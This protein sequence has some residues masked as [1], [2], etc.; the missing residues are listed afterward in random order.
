MTSKISRKI[1]AYHGKIVSVTN[2]RYRSWEHCY[3]FFQK[4]QMDAI[5]KDREHAALHLAFYL[6]SWGMYRGSCWLLQYD[7]TVHLHVVDCL[8]APA[9]RPLWNHEFGSGEG[10]AER[11][12]VIL[13]AVERVR[14]AYQKTDEPTNLLITKVLL[15]TLGCIPAFD[16]FFTDGFKSEGLPCWALNEA[17][18]NRILDFTHNNLDTLQAEQA[19]IKTK[20][21]CFYP[22]MKLVD[23][24]FWQVGYERALAK[25]G[26]KPPVED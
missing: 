18:L 19:R 20:T 17:L 11:V 3:Q 2:Y 15:G 24:Y 14:R 16:Q 25:R 10:D 12:P 6:A 8:V 21:R 1:Q 23:M 4:A 7:F 5:A 13:D 22:L 9:S 26:G